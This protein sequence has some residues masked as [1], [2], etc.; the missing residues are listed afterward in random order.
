MQ[1]NGNPFP[2]ET[3]VQV[4]YPVTDDQPRDE[5]R[6]LPGTALERCGRDDW[7]VCVEVREL[8]TREDGSKPRRNTP[9]HKLFYPMCFRDASDIR[10][11]GR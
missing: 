7:R 4:R 3:P 2:D 10:R 8:A 9:R 5:W 6:W 11:T 1:G